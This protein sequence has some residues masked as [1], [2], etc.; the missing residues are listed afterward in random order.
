MRSLSYFIVHPKE[1]KRYDNTKD[2][3][4]VAINVSSTN[5]DHS[6][7]QRIG[8][9]DALPMTYK[10]DIQVGDEIIVH[11][12]TF[13]ITKDMKGIERSGWHHLF[14]DKFMVPKEEIFAYRRAN[15]TWQAIAPF[16]F[17]SPI[18]DAPEGTMPDVIKFNLEEAQLWG[19]MVY[20][21][22][23]Q[24]HIQPGELVSYIPDSEYEFNIEG[25]KLYRMKTNMICLV[26][27]KKY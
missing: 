8:V 18:K 4:G 5:E 12:N 21:N 15:S 13:R 1:G 26:S 14:G 6:V 11:H 25:K 17:I 27:G 20:P 3:S 23:D 2:I 16:C 9:V 19:I 7:T 10:G 24:R 22:E